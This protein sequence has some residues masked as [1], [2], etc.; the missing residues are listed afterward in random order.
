VFI[1]EMV[2]GVLASIV[3]AWFSRKR[4]FRADIGG[5]ELAGKPAMIGALEKLK[6][7]Q[8]SQ[9]EGSMMAF[10]INN[11]AKFLSLFASH[12]PLDV[13]IKALRDNQ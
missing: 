13:R 5:A 8:E 7:S 12:P 4:E 9:L 2:L 6:R 10:G 11:K 3:V 1:L